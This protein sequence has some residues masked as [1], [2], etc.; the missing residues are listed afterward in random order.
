MDSPVVRAAGPEDEA[1]VVYVILLAFAADPVARWANPDPARYVATMPEFIRAFG[2]N[3]FAHNSVDL[4]ADGA[5]A[6]MWLPPGVEPDVERMGELI[7]RDV[8]DAVMGDLSAV[9]EEMGHAHPEEPHWYLP[10]IGVDPAMHSRG[11]GSALLRHALARADADGV[12]AYLESS[13]PRN[14]DLYQRHGFE[15][16]RTIQVGSSPPVV[17]M[18]RKPR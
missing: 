12:P 9:M 6:A 13:N 11:V 5:G 15:I 18:L 4:A 10:M 7:A 14:I 1:A 17:P 2:G 3:G 16:L 8:P